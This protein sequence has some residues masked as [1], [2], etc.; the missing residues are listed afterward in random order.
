M[1]G[2]VTGSN[3]ASITIAKWS[4]Y[5]LY[6]K[7]AFEI[8]MFISVDLCCPQSSSEKKLSAVVEVYADTQPIGW[9]KG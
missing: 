6:L 4:Y 1:T 9:E 5:F 2:E 3:R 8:F 7:R